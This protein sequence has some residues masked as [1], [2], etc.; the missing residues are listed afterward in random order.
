M[1][2][3]YA[4]DFSDEQSKKLEYIKTL[5]SFDNILEFEKYYKADI[6]KCLDDRHNDID[7]ISCLLEYEIWD[8]ELDITY[9]KLF[10]QLDANGKSD[11]K[12]AQDLWKQVRTLNLELFSTHLEQEQGTMYRLINAGSID[13]Y[14]ST[15]TKNRTMFLRLYIK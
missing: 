9:E 2:F 7:G 5:S 15:F 11:L 13:D 8:R 6:Q 1:N 12:K 4:D 14:L 10:I 3:I